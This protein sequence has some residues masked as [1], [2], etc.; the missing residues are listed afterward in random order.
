MVTPDLTS[1]TGILVALAIISVNMLSWLGS[2]CWIS[3]NAI[4]VSNGIAWKNSLYASRPPA[5]APTATMGKEP[6]SMGAP[7]RLGRSMGKMRVWM[8]GISLSF[9]P[10]SF[11]ATCSTRSCESECGKEPLAFRVSYRRAKASKPRH[12]SPV[13]TTLLAFGHHC[14]RRSERGP[15]TSIYGKSTIH[16]LS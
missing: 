9:A 16:S 4:P 7:S 15:V 10:T 1:S 5:E 8:D 2:R 6:F 11:D 14:P 3:T 12:S 13:R